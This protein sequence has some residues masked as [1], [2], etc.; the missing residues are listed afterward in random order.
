MVKIWDLEPPTPIHPGGPLRGSVPPPPNRSPPWRLS[1]SRGSASFGVH[2][3]GASISA[4]FCR[5]LCTLPPGGPGRKT[6]VSPRSARVSC[7]VLELLR[8]YPVNSAPC[9][10]GRG[11]DTPVLFT[12]ALVAEAFSPPPRFLLGL[13]NGWRPS[14]RPQCLAPDVVCS[15]G[16]A[17]VSNRRLSSFFLRRSNLGNLP[18]P[19]LRFLPRVLG[20]GVLPRSLNLPIGF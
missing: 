11:S 19:T 10:C 8:D 3:L 9:V 14:L 6:V 13:W 16:P 5:R 2:R 12:V 4:L 15:P 1:W 18:Q 20:D 17:G 7:Q